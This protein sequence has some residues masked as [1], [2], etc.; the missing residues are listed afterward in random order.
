MDKDIF[1]MT[2]APFTAGLEVLR[3]RI[4]VL[5]G[6]KVGTEEEGGFAAKSERL[7]K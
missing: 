6:S 1:V 5:D 2:N 4:I 7:L 3:V